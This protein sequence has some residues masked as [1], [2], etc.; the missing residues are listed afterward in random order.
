LTAQGPGK[1]FTKKEIG[2]GIGNNMIFSALKKL[3][4][5]DGKLSKKDDKFSL[6]ETKAQ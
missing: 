3:T 1:S 6:P 2:A 4:E 5:K